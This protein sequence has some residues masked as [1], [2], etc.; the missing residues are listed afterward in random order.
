MSQVLKVASLDSAHA[1]MG[2]VVD[3]RVARRNKTGLLSK[4]DQELGTGLAVTWLGTSSSCPMH[5]RNVSCTLVRMPEAMYIVDCGEGSQRQIK[6]AGLDVALTESIFITHLHGDHCFG[7]ASMLLDIDEA[8][9]RAIAEVGPNATMCGVA[10][11]D[12]AEPP[13]RPLTHVYGPVGTSDLLR[14]SL[15]LTGQYARM[16]GQVVM[17]ELVT[18]EEE[19]HPPQAT[20]DSMATRLQKMPS[21]WSPPKPKSY[22]KQGY[23]ADREIYWELPCAHA[24]VRAAQLQH[25]LQA[26]GYVFVE[27][28][29]AMAPAQRRKAVILGDA[30]DSAPIAPHSAGADLLSHDFMKLRL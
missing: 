21:L 26:W 24:F 8:K 12:A 13:A 1:R 5:G 14:V 3:A 23:V 7:L 20:S 2:S 18:S 29:P 17:V 4:E 16:K 10:S 28:N 9:A 11:A 6:T 22:G 30:I 27:K 19:A 15:M 25:R